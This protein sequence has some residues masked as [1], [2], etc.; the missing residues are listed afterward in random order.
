MKFWLKVYIFSLR[1]GFL[2]NSFKSY[3][4]FDNHILIVLSWVLIRFIAKYYLFSLKLFLFIISVVLG[5][6]SCVRGFFFFSLVVASRASPPAG[7][8]FSLLVVASPAVERGLGG[9]DSWVLELRP[10]GCGAR[11]SCSAV[12]GVFPDQVS[13]CVSCTGR[14]ILHH[15]AT[16]EAPFLQLLAQ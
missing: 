7:P 2:R 16:R 14:R 1:H 13:S 11:L 5:L 12:C 8:G 15:W 6:C 9:C 4:T 10:E 3:I